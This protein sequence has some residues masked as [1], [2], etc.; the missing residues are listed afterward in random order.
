MSADN[1]WKGLRILVTGTTSGIGRALVPRLLRGG[2]TVLVHGRTPTRVNAVVEETKIAGTSARAFAADFKS[3]AEVDSLATAVNADGPLDVVVHNAGVGFGSDRTR[4]EVSADGLELR[5]AVNYAAPLVLT[6]S[7]LARGATPRVVIH[8]ASIGQELI[9]FEDLQCEKRYD[10][11]QAYRRSKL[12]LIMQAIDLAQSH[13]E[14]AANAV[15]PGSFLDTEMV[16]VAGVAP[17]GPPESGAEAIEKVLGAS[18]EHK[19]TGT[20]FNEQVPARALDVAY[21][22]AYRS[23]FSTLAFAA[24]RPHVSPGLI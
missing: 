16:R 13:P 21:D 18:L 22:S 23:V 9:D 24:I 5:F 20:Y 8:V 15:H 1:P 11:V 19:V 4:R 3:L 2:A 6:R 10:G 14:I 7:L 12:A 17:L